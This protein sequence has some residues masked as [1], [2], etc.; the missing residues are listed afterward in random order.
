[1]QIKFGTHTFEATAYPREN[2][3]MMVASFI[4]TGTTFE[5]LK[6]ILHNPK[7]TNVIVFV[8]EGEHEIEYR[9]YSVYREL[10]Y[11]DGEDE[12]TVA[13]VTLKLEDLATKVDRLAALIEAQ[14]I[15]I[16]DTN[17]AIDEIMT[18]VIPE[19]LFGDLIA[20]DDEE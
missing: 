4:A 20:V 18:V 5:D 13:T 8:D 16:E 14:A 17:T 12:D 11:T 15:S 2:G 1:M 19:L 9:N 10:Q 7:N 6:E 3:E